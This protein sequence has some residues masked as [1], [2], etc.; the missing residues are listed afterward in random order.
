MSYNLS[1]NEVSEKL[2]EF[3]A[4]YQDG[5]AAVVDFLQ[6]LREPIAG[7]QPKLYCIQELPYIDLLSIDEVVLFKDGFFDSEAKTL[8]NRRAHLR[9]RR[10]ASKQSIPDK[11]FLS[12][13]D[14]E[15]STEYVGEKLIKGALEIKNDLP[16][17][18]LFP[19]FIAEYTCVRLVKDGVFI[20]IVEIIPQQYI[21]LV[22]CHLKNATQDD[23]AA[24]E[25][26]KAQVLFNQSLKHTNPG[27]KAHLIKLDAKTFDKPSLPLVSALPLAVT[28]LFEQVASFEFE[29]KSKQVNASSSSSP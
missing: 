16:L 11:W 3:S 14:P 6:P 1:H 9:Q 19:K 20:D 27:V 5:F 24:Y 21:I 22:S 13:M 18:I 4:M 17:G 12:M 15:S 26:F 8:T 23:V 7:N 28:T 2:L 29:G 25:C 10:T